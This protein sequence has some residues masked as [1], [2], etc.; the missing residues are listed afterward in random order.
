MHGFTEEKSSLEQNDSNRE[1]QI[2][3]EEDEIVQQKSAEQAP[4]QVQE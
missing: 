3:E 1:H 2:M 4:I